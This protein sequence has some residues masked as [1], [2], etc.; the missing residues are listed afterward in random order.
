MQAECGLVSAGV[1]G[2]GLIGGQYGFFNRVLPRLVS[3]GVKNS[4]D[5]A[6]SR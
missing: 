6:V 2:T 1:R 3:E 5:E 4:D